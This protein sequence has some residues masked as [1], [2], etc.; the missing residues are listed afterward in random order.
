MVSNN[1]IQNFPITASD[2]TNSHIMFGKNLS[3]TRVKT[4]WQKPDRVVMDY[5]AVTNDFIK[6]HKFVTLV[7]DVMFVN[8]ELFLI[9]MPHVINF[10]T[11]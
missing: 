11:I 9:T 4:V 7:A 10:V 5:V 2:V 8:C 3:G 6:L 1:I